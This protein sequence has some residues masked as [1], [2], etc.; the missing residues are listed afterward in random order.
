[1]AAGDGVMADEDMNPQRR[2]Q[3]L[4]PKRLEQWSTGA[5]TGVDAAAGQQGAGSFVGAA[6]SL[7]QSEKPDL[8]QKY[9]WTGVLWTGVL[10]EYG[11]RWYGTGQRCQMRLAGGDT[12]RGVGIDRSR[13]RTAAGDME[14]RCPL[15]SLGLRGSHWLSWAPLAVHSCLRER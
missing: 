6:R 14:L 5:P 15:E 10:V 8:M 4:R 2:E 12:Q 3:G 9:W 1:M 7:V 13:S 11:E